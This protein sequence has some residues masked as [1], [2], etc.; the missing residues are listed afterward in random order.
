MVLQMT[1]VLLNYLYLNYFV[2]E[3]CYV[4]DNVNNTWAIYVRVV[5]HPAI[6]RDIPES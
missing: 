1:L 4:N 3:L 6:W 5:R 2:L